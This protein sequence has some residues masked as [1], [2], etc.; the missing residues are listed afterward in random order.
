MLVQIVPDFHPEFTNQTDLS[1]ISDEEFEKGIEDIKCSTTDRIIQI[2]LF[3][4]TLGW[5][6]VFLLFTILILAYVGLFPI[7]ICRKFFQTN[8]FLFKIELF[9]AQLCVRAILFTLGIYKINLN[10]K[11]SEKARLI[12]IN[13]TTVLDG[14]VIFSLFHFNPI[15]MSSVHKIPFF[16]VILECV[17]ALWIDRSSA[18]GNS[19]IISDRIADTTRRPCC[20]TCEG[21][22]TTGGF[23]L[24]FRTGAF[25][26]KT[27]FQPVTL[28]YYSYYPFG[29]VGFRWR[30]GGFLEWIW[31]CFCVPFAKIEIDVLDIIEEEVFEKL[32]P[33]ERAN[34]VALKMANHLGL[35]ATDRSSGNVFDKKKEE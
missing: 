12:P 23:M 1:P 17:D 30:V 16:G 7:F 27:T 25:L 4:L 20:I 13:H 14:P 22:T 10:G 29:K 5:F 3:I 24:K 26:N 34:L 31:R 8:A 19:R 21:M 15:C 11:F 2:A 18:H 33:T 9:Y 35:K 6:R 32:S 28:R